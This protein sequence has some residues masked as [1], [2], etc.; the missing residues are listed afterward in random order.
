MSVA[1]SAASALCASSSGWYWLQPIREAV[2]GDWVKFIDCGVSSSE[3]KDAL[4]V[5]HVA[6]LSVPHFTKAVGCSRAVSRVRAPVRLADAV[7]AETNRSCE[8]SA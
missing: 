6:E 4:Q 8:C 7:V 1:S 5:E 3:V 2:R